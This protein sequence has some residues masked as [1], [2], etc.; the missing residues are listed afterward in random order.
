[1]LATALQVVG[2]QWA[3]DGTDASQA[4]CGSQQPCVEED[5]LVSATQSV[6]DVVGVQ[7]EVLKG[8]GHH[9]QH[10]SACKGGGTR[11]LQL[12]NCWSWILQPIRVNQNLTLP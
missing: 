8:K 3:E 10:G 9:R 1:M 6:R 5:E 7:V 4:Q 2:P 11:S 12:K